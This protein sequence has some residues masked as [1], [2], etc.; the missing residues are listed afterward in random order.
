MTKQW[1][2]TADARVRL[3][4]PSQPAPLRQPLAPR[5]PDASA[6]EQLIDAAT[7]AGV[8]P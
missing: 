3:S 2:P 1:S 6:N 4:S 7:D 8:H 5:R